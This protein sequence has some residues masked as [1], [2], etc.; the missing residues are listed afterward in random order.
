MSDRAGKSHELS[1]NLS[2]SG[3]LI[4][5]HRASYV[6]AASILG[7]A[8]SSCSNVAAAAGTTGGAPG[9]TRMGGS[10]TPF[11]GQYPGPGS[12]SPGESPTGS[13]GSGS[14]GSSSG[15]A[16]AGEG[17][18][19]PIVIQ[20]DDAT[21][22]AGTITGKPDWPR[23]VPSDIT[24]TAGKQVTLLIVDYD[25]M[26]TPIQSMQSM[27]SLNS[28]S[29]GQES[30]NGKAVSAVGNKDIA[31]TF[32]VMSL[33]IN[34]PIPVA[35]KSGSG[36]TAVVTPSIVTFTFTP[37]H[38]GTFTWQC[39]TPCGTGSDGL[40]GPMVQQGYMRGILNVT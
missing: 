20:R 2:K 10:S 5:R 12:G 1:G 8:I 4:L 30:V 36:N 38:T 15:D 31:H 9:I 17:E 3:L 29:G 26:N 16:Q 40:G 28:A 35:E 23:F 13:A 14:L 24:V 18:L 34:V 21:G 32:T 25:D 6:L 19:I 33:G 22:L 11:A 39:F 37:E 27:M 7:V